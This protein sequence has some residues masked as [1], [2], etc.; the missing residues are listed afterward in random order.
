MCYFLCIEVIKLPES[1]H[2]WLIP[3][4]NAWACKIGRYAIDRWWL[5]T[6]RGPLFSTSAWELREA[7]HQRRQKIQSSLN[8]KVFSHLTST[9]TKNKFFIFSLGYVLKCFWMIGLFS[10]GFHHL[11]ITQLGRKLVLL[12][13]P[14][15]CFTSTNYVATDIV[16]Y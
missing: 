1:Q 8:N 11:L 14:E 12:Q 15:W 13:L 4:G 6:H 7:R 16:S 9:Y 2:R 10:T 3:A 5:Q